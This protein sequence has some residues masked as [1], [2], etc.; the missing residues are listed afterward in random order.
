M[1]NIVQH[2]TNSRLT[3]KELYSVSCSK[4]VDILDMD[5][6]V[7]SGL[8][9]Q[10]VNDGGVEIGCGCWFFA[11]SDEFEHKKRLSLDLDEWDSAEISCPE[12][13][14]RLSV[15]IPHVGGQDKEG[16]QDGRA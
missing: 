8:S 16:K 11:T 2:G 6:D 12:C 10:S 9:S 1:I 15:V 14:I 7:V 3:E 4:W 5:G 13:G